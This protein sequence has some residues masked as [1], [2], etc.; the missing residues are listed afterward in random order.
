[1]RDNEHTIAQNNSK[2]IK[3]DIYHISPPKKHDKSSKTNTVNYFKL[4]TE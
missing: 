1:M 3:K 2:Y 4:L